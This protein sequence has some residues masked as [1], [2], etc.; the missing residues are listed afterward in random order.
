MTALAFFIG[1]PLIMG[2]GAD[3]PVVVSM[4]YSYS[5]WAATAIGSTL[6]HDL[7]IVTGALGWSSS[8]NVLWT[9]SA[10]RA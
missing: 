3:M 6:G 10:F 5:D 7:L 2:I 1:C 4:L 9:L 8:G